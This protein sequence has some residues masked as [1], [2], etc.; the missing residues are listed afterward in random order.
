MKIPRILAFLTAF[1]IAMP[2]GA[3][4][5]AE[6]D[7]WQFMISPM[8]LWAAGIEGTSQVGPVAAP[9]DIEFKDAL[10][11]LDAGFTIHGEA[12]KGDW[13]ILVDYFTLRL[14]PSAVIKGPVAPIT[15]G[16]TGDVDLRND[17]AEL[18]GTYKVFDQNNVAIEVLGGFRY[19][20]V[21]VDARIQSG[22]QV[23]DLEEDWWDFFGGTRVTWSLPHRW[24]L[25]GRGDIGAGGSNLVWNVDL[26]AD[27]RYKDWGSVFGGYRWLDYDYETGSGA[28]RFTWDVTY[29]GPLLGLGFYF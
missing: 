20:R 28:S 1:V 24:S 4:A 5:P 12:G 23:V 14:D 29:Q 3:E 26:M 10:D 25:R 16:Q 9:I 22:P 15:G 17:I 2:A 27:W 11:N 19:T 7:G 21:D 18:G 6:D 8:Y 13:R